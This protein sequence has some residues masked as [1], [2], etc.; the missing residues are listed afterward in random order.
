LGI[1]APALLDSPNSCAFPTIR[2][3]DTLKG[4]FRHG[5]LG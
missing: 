1:I 3:N 5:L 4:G 2:V